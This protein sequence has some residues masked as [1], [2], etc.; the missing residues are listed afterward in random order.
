MLIIFLH[1]SILKIFN[2]LLFFNPKYPTA[3]D[4]TPMNKAATP[5]KSPVLGSCP[6]LLV[7]F[8]L[9]PEVLDAT[10]LL[11]LFVVVPEATLSLPV[12][13]LSLLF[14]LPVLVFPPFSVDSLATK[15]SIAPCNSFSTF[16][17]SVLVASS[18]SNTALAL[19]RVSCKLDQDEAVYWLA[20]KVSTLLIK[21]SNLSLLGFYLNSKNPLKTSL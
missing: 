10:L 2:Y 11:P 9:F 13:A 20:S 17:I 14:P 18:F 5:P 21:S 16:A 3:K 15:L 8:V 7:L 19:P 12:L 4:V 1:F 6:L